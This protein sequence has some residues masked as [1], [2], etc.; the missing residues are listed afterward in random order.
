M[1]RLCLQVVGC[2]SVAGQVDLVAAEPKSLPRKL[3][4]V[5]VLLGMLRASVLGM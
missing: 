4:M 3:I 1:C 2:F 5:N